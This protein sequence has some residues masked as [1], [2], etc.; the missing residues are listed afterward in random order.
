M[1][2]EAAL[3]ESEERY[4]AF[5][6]Q[7]AEGVW[8]IELERPVS[9]LLSEDEQIDRFYA[10]GVLAE[11]NDAMAHMYGFEQA[12]ELVGARLGEL[13]PRSDP[14][15]LE[16]LRAFIRNGYRLTEAQSHELDREGNERYFL[17]N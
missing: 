14:H 2:T 9:V 11:C 8:R 4:R 13:T 16:F 15:N 3:R 17:N 12:E 7:T 10:H 1:E 5:I 6:E